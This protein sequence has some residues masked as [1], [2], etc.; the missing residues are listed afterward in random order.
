MI[1]SLPLT[2]VIFDCDGVL[3]DTEPLHYRAFQEVLGPLGLGHDYEHYLKCYVGF[4]DRDAFLRILGDSGRPT[5]PGLLH[6]LIRAKNKALLRLSSAGISSFPGVMELVDELAAAKVPLAVASGSLHHEV[7]AFL[8]AL[9]LESAFSAIVASDD[10]SRSKPD[11]ETYVTA[12][13]KLRERKGMTDIDLGRTIAV[14]DTPA[15]IQS[16]RG[17]GLFV[18]GVANSYPSSR[19]SGAHHVVESM[20][21]LNLSKL[22]QLI[23]TSGT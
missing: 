1:S 9:E 7:M 19:L 15:G 21:E 11:P 22:I 10:V 20:T 18:I 14:E 12:V 16:A 23:E 8:R 5:E 13:H 17:A 2:A 4:D 3:A 6:D